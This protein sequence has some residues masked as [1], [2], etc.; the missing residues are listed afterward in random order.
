[1]QNSLVFNSFQ[2]HPH[3][4]SSV[5]EFTKSLLKVLK[6]E[7]SH[8]TYIKSKLHPS[9]CQRKSMAEKTEKP[10]EEMT[11]YLTMCLMKMLQTHREAEFSLTGPPKGVPV[12]HWHCCLGPCDPFKATQSMEWSELEVFR[13]FTFGFGDNCDMLEQSME[14]MDA[15]YARN[16]SILISDQS[17]HEQDFG[18]RYTPLILIP[19]RVLPGWVKSHIGKFCKAYAPKLEGLFICPTHLRFGIQQAPYPGLTGFTFHG[20]RTQLFFEGFRFDFAI[21]KAYTQGGYASMANDLASYFEVDKAF[22]RRDL[23]PFVGDVAALSIRGSFKG[24]EAKNAPH[25]YRDSHDNFVFSQT[26]KGPMVQY[27]GKSKA[28]NV[29][30]IK[31]TDPLT[32]ISELQARLSNMVHNCAGIENFLGEVFFLLPPY[33]RL[34]ALIFI[35]QAYLEACGLREMEENENGDSQSVIELH[36]A[37]HKF[38]DVAHIELFILNLIEGE[39]FLPYDLDENDGDINS[40]V[41]L[42]KRVIKAQ[43]KKVSKKKKKQKSAGSTRRTA[44]RRSSPTTVNPEVTQERGSLYENSVAGPSSRVDA[45]VQT[46]R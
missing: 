12:S 38:C 17:E 20:L 4:L 6:D 28:A 3:C 5:Q 31:T 34:L 26:E 36:K 1:M 18:S 21:P 15:F 19:V 29:K 37:F 2:A 41:I 35:H 40:N 25:W 43:K 46:C 14:G 11:E 30:P 24:L 8:L 23:E 27:R 44:S 9:L 22:K 10:S 33:Q 32:T 7:Q 45:Q 16:G 39:Y 42:A 13:Y